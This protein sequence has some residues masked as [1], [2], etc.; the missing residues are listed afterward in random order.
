MGVYGRV[1]AEWGGGGWVL[2]YATGP[3]LR[4]LRQAP[5]DHA[6]QRVNY[7]LYGKGMPRARKGGAEILV[8]P[9]PT[10]LGHLDGHGR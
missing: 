8:A 9:A 5:A 1:L 2:A 7:I 4:E 3:S 10:I 6:L